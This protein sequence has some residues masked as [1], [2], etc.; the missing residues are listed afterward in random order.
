ML[1]GLANTTLHILGAVFGHVA[2]LIAVETDRVVIV[3][4]H[5]ASGT[6]FPASLGLV[7]VIEADLE[8][9]EAHVAQDAAT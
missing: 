5:M 3:L 2:N 6:T 4:C 9:P 1:L 8:L 7:I